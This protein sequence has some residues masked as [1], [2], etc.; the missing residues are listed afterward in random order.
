MHTI[1]P[2]EYYRYDKPFTGSSAGKRYRILHCKEEDSTEM[3]KVWIWPEP[4]A[5]EHT[6]E[7]S[8]Q[9]R[10]FA[11]SQDGYEQMLSYLNEEL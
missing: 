6:E 9:I 1:Y 4:F 3:L 2:L 7:E 11:Y 8:M 5:F 10:T